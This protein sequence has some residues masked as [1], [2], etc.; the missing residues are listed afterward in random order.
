MNKQAE[1]L[2]KI[3]AVLIASL[4]LNAAVK[5]VPAQLPKPIY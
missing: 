1:I 4:T 3:M 5:D 2:L